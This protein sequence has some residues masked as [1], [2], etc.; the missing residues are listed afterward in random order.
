MSG[1]QCYGP[2]FGPFA[3]IDGHAAHLLRPSAP[4]ISQIGNV[5]DIVAQKGNIG[6]VESILEG[7]ET[8]PNRIQFQHIDVQLFMASDHLAE[9]V[10]CPCEH[11]NPQHL[12][13]W[14]GK[15]R[16]EET[17]VGF[18]CGDSNEFS[19]REWN[20]GSLDPD[21]PGS[22]DGLWFE[23]ILSEVGTEWVGYAT[24]RSKLVSLGKLGA[25]K[26]V[27][28]AGQAGPVPLGDP[29]RWRAIVRSSSRRGRRGLLWYR[30]K[31]PRKWLHVKESGLTSPH[32]TP[33]LGVCKR[34]ITIG[35]AVWLTLPIW[36]FNQ[37]I[38][39]MDVEADP[40]EKGVGH[41][42]CRDRYKHWWWSV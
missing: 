5:R 3:G 34:P 38:V 26:V 9:V 30:A 12:S 16:S 28:R 19:T 11:P 39:Q 27:T 20:P 23:T 37:P 22:E 40:I 1:Y 2:F 35:F 41:D 33:N 6:V 10:L 32:L 8:K 13:L 7:L 42:R 29:P 15:L 17:L 25:P 31:I 21:W 18:L 14:R 36:V 4:L 24:G